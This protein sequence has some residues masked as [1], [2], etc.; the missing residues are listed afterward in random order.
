MNFQ[1]G[2]QL[3]EVQLEKCHSTWKS[4]VQM[5]LRDD[6]LHQCCRWPMILQLEEGKVRDQI[7]ESDCSIAKTHLRQMLAPNGWGI[8]MKD[9]KTCWL[10]SVVISATIGT[11]MCKIWVYAS[12][13]ALSKRNLQNEGICS[14]K[15]WRTAASRSWSNRSNTGMR[16]F[17]VSSSPICF[18]DSARV[19]IKYNLYREVKIVPEDYW[20]IIWMISKYETIW[21]ILSGFVVFDDEFIFII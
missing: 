3:E 12:S 2:F 15:A 8:K 18:A 5:R 13:F 1:L 10:G 14:T 19:R 11:K 7:D 9:R 20:K 16:C 21:W 17:L 4:V 6:V